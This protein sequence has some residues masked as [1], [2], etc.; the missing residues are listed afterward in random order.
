MSKFD[1]FMESIPV[2]STIIDLLNNL[3]KETSMSEFVHEH[4]FPADLGEFEEIFHDNQYG[5]DA[6]TQTIVWHSKKYD[7]FVETHYYYDSYNGDDFSD[8]V[9]KEVLPMLRH[10]KILLTKTKLKQL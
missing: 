5:D 3:L 4:K 9:F 6:N 7:V 2:E 1:E 8:S 10:I